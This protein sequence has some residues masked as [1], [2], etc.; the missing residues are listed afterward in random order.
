M[1][2]AFKIVKLNL[3]KK[4]YNKELQAFVSSDVNFVIRNN[5]LWTILYYWRRTA[6]NG[7]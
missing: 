4:K 1:N 7:C 6:T 3:K 2:K 5:V